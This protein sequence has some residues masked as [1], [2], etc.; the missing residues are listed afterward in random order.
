[1]RAAVLQTDL[2]FT[3]EDRPI[4][5]PA[6][7]QVLVR[8]IHS[9]VCGSDVHI[10]LEG[11]AAP[12]LVGE[13]GFP[14]HEGV[15][16]VEES[17]SPDWHPGDRVLTVPLG[18]RGR[19]F[20]EYAVVDPQYLLPLEDTD[21]LPAVLMGQQLGT[22]VAALDKFWRPGMRSAVVIGL[23]SAGQFFVQQLVGRGLDV[24]ASD[25]DEARIGHGA[26]FGAHAMHAD[27][28]SEAVTAAYPNG[29]DLVVEAAGFDVSR[30]QAIDLV[31][32]HGVVGCFGYPE[33]RVGTFPTMMAFRK[34][35]TIEWFS[36]AQTFPGVPCFAR[37]LD[38][39]RTGAVKVEPMIETHMPLADIDAAVRRAQG[40]GDGAAKIVID[41]AAP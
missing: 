9:S 33:E 36:D 20:A 4:P 6:D 16:I 2:R 17:R 3:V 15:G 41:I 21:D 1:M 37:A 32:K 26:L 35:V 23:G 30:A 38:L 8:M 5:S 27:A 18:S 39:I 11:W 25:L 7:G 13:P 19:L 28:L 40:R 24:Y 22:T 10:A 12:E 31:R 14:G 29:V 34:S